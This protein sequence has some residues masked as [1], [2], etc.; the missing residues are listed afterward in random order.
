[1]PPTI[2]TLWGLSLSF[3]PI[4]MT[5]KSRHSMSVFFRVQHRQNFEHLGRPVVCMTACSAGMKL[6]I[7]CW[8]TLAWLRSSR[9]DVGGRSRDGWTGEALGPHEGWRKTST[10]L[11]RRVTW[12]YENVL[13]KT[14]LLYRH[15]SSF[16]HTMMWSFLSWALM[17]GST[18]WGPFDGPRHCSV[19]VTRGFRGWGEA[20]RG[21]KF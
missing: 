5:V 9:L 7:W 10:S 13:H 3:E 15:H 19:F 11:T 1:M 21:M 14:A 18:E 2:T 6:H 8:W 16:E 17:P 4:L 12:S 20:F